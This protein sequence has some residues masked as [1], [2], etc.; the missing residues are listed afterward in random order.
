[1]IDLY[2]WPTPNCHK[3]VLFLEETGLPYTIK[4][5]E[6]RQGAQYSKTYLAIN[7][8]NRVPA[9]IDHTAP[10]GSE[11]VVFESGAILLYLADRTGKF[12]PHGVRKK[13]EVLQWLFWQM[14]GLGPML[15]QNQVFR[16]KMPECIP[17]AIDRYTK[18]TARLY[19]VLDRQLA[20]NEFV[21]GEYSIADM[22]C[23]PWVL[24]D[25]QGQN[26][27]DFP[28]LMRWHA[29]LSVRP[30]VRRTYERARE[31]APTEKSVVAFFSNDGGCVVDR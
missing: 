17:L 23:F 16:E 30:A 21:A 9:I 22:A 5:I 1:M 28:H 7:P 29:A 31:I 26:K 10:D 6:I 3:V 18:E 14:S 13:N 24:P 8:N 4:P 25:R 27:E 20:S 15:G 2:Y 11:L 12:L 19:K